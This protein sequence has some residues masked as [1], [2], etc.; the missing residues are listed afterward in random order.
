[1]VSEERERERGGREG[2]GGR[3]WVGWKEEKGG[4]LGSEV[5]FGVWEYVRWG[6]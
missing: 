3:G 2:G 5:G 6:D 4:L 1:M